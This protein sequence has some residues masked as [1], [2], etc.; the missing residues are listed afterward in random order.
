M[1]VVDSDNAVESRHGDVD[2]AY[3]I[4]ALFRQ[5]VNVSHV[6]SVFGNAN[7]PDVF[8]S[9]SRLL[10]VLQANTPLLRGAT[11]A[12][13]GPTAASRYLQTLREPIN[14]LCLGPLTNLARA[15]KDNPQIVST[16][17]NVTV[18]GTNYTWPLP[19]L[20]FF[21]FNQW[22]DPQAFRSVF[23]SAIPLTIVP[24]DVARKLR[25][26]L[27][28]ISAVNS[29]IGTF[30]SEKSIRWFRRAL[31]LKARRSVPL[32]DLAAVML[33]SEP[34][35]FVCQQTRASLGKFGQVSY[36]RGDKTINV[37]TSFDAPAVLKKVLAAL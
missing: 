15:L 32:W 33:H 19:A 17:R 26:T 1:L 9:H 28:Q 29:K 18:V 25:V 16:I 12:G 6:L 14:L 11:R 2:D 13:D 34:D 10:S 24:C 31:F 4:A 20:R 7:E 35:L 27:A 21:D 8:N 36:G 23:S 37:V 22:L 30:L 5:R 3:A